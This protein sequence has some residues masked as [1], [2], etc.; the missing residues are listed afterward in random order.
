[1]N[2]SLAPAP[3]DMHPSGAERPALFLSASVPDGVKVYEG[4]ER[5][6]DTAR[7]QWIRDAVLAL[8]RRAFESE[9]DLVFGAHPSISPMLLT[10]AREFPRLG[11]PRAHVYLSEFF[12]AEF[13]RETLEL[14]DPSLRLG[15]LEVTSNAADRET[16]LRLMRRAMFERPGLCA[17]V[18]VGGMDG[19]FD[20]ARLFRATNPTLPN[21]AIASAGGAALDL[22][23]PPPM[24]PTTE[25]CG[26]PAAPIDGGVLRATHVGYTQVARSIIHAI[27]AALR[28]RTIRPR[29]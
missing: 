2:L 16:A 6:R 15:T 14:T 11:S 26:A 21:Y 19:I 7:P 17:A 28:A 23:G 24:P 10:V 29:A 18:F 5:H 25:Y 1:M 3:D 13:P 4:C 8:A 27:Q 20:E 22:V 9:L 12:R